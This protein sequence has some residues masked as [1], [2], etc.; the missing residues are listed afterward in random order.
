MVIVVVLV[1]LVGDESE[2]ERT[3]IITLKRTIL[4]VNKSS[5]NLQIVSTAKLALLIE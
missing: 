3:R 4:F 1:E 2:T 5:D